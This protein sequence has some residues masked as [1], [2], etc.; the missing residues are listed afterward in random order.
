MKKATNLTEAAVLSLQVSNLLSAYRGTPDRCMCGCAG[1]YFYVAA[2]ARKASKDRGY[3]VDADEINDAA[4][5]RIL[6]KVQ[7]AI[8]APVRKDLRIGASYASIVVGKTQYTIY[9]AI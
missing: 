9:P 6:S 8:K 4:A 5:A 3:K 2:N 1:K 7:K